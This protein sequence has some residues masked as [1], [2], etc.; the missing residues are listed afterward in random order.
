MHAEPQCPT[1]K[2]YFTKWEVANLRHCK[3]CGNVL[4][5]DRK[6][7]GWDD[8]LLAKLIATESEPARYYYGNGR[9]S[10]DMCI[11][12]ERRGRHLLHD[13]SCPETRCERFWWDG[14]ASA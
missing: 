10:N 2:T 1:C 13:Y 4:R 9:E 12:G 14:V 11:C 8:G 7:E 5:Y 6:D 3:H